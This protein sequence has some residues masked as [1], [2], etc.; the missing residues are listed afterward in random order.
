M[1]GF[2]TGGTGFIGGAVVRALL[3]AGH[4]V[5]TLVRP[6]AD[7]QQLDGLPVARVTGDLA[8]REGLRRGIRGCD[9][10][11]HVAALYRYWGYRWQ[12]Y[13]QA[14]I[15][16]T[17]HV[18]EAAR[19]ERV[20]RVVYTSSTVSYTHLRAPE[21]VLD[22]VCRLLLEK[23]KQKYKKKKKQFSAEH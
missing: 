20:G 21:N 7:T 12:D 5:R 19:L 6:G 23:K 8:D 3:A 17:R 2:V 11:F 1:R 9:W 15:V 13:E 14:N 4:E 16:G 18:L 22:I 10:V